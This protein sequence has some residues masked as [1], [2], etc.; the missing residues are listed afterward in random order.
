[1]PDE[2]VPG[3]T[4]SPTQTLSLPQIYALLRANGAS[5]QDALDLTQISTREDGSG[6]INVVNNTPST[7]DYSVGFFQINYLGSLMGPRTQAYGSPA[8]LASSPMAQV[9]AALKLWNSGKGASNWSPHLQSGVVEPW[10][11]GTNNSLAIQAQQAAESNYM[12]VANGALQSLGLPSV[13]DTPPITPAWDSSTSGSSSGDGSSGGGVIQLNS[14][15][16]SGVQT[17][18]GNAALGTIVGR[19]ASPGFWWSAGFIIVAG[20]FLL[21]GMIILFRKDIERTAGAAMAAA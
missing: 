8:Q 16:S 20:L 12:G 19:L 2:P 17:L 11:Y 3:A 7:G 21:I 13:D 18:F 5:P 4:I 9:Q 1:M 15:G 10:T 14:D 6:T